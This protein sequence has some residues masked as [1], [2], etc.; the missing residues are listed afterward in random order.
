M[1]HPF[2]EDEHRTKTLSNDIRCRFRRYIEEGWTAR[3]TGQA[4]KISPA[5]AARFRQMILQG[6]RLDTK[7]RGGHLGGGK[8]SGFIDFMIELVIQDSDITLYELRDALEAAHGV[9]V[10]HSSVDR[11]LRRA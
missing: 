11:A 3:A 8:L 1:I 9:W 5:S 6:N 10:H 2:Q 4:L 7:P